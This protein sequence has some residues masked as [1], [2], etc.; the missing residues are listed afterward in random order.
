[1]LRRIVLDTC[2]MSVDILKKSIVH[3]KQLRSLKFY[4]TVFTSFSVLWEV[5][6]TLPS[7]ANLYLD[8]ADLHSYPTHVLENSYSQ[9]GGP[10]YFNA[11]ESLWAVGS[12]F[13][14]QDLLGIIHSP[15]LESIEVY[16]TDL[17]LVHVRNEHELE[18]FFTASMTAIASKWSQ[19]LKKLVIASKGFARL[20]P[21]SKSLILLTGL[22]EMQALS[23]HGWRI[24]NM[25]DD[26]GRLVKSWPKIRTLH[27]DETLISLSTLKIIAENCPELR[28]L[29]IRLDISTIP[30]F[31]TP[32]KRLSHKL[33]V[34]RVENIH[35]SITPITL[36]CQIEMTRFLDLI[37][38]YLKA[39]YVWDSDG[40]WLDI[41]DLVKLCQDVRR[42]E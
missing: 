19:S 23:L 2:Q 7:L 37:F 6:G 28:H 9:S 34:L 14:I 25:D 4:N 40:T 29:Q 31:D 32:S 33:E 26:V 8:D 16:C 42:A 39:M 11:L 15:C 12:I 27:L 36:K 3:F 30:P 17:D 10:N 41:W 5:L 24:E 13:L 20:N 35:P 38:P 22:R 21:I 18:D 1:M